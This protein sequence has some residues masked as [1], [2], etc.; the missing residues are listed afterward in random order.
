[1]ALLHALVQ[2]HL[3]GM[4]Q[5]NC[6]KE[7]SALPDAEAGLGLFHA[8]HTAL[9]RQATDYCTSGNTALARGD[10][11]ALAKR[12][13]T[14]L[15]GLFPFG[16]ASNPDA[17]LAVTKRFFLDY[18]AQRGELR[19]KI[20][21]AGKRWQRV[22]AFLDRLDTAADFFQTS[23]A[24]GSQSRPLGLDVTFRYLPQAFDRAL[25]GSSQLIGWRFETGGAEASYP[26]G[27]TSLNWRFGDPV[28]MHLNWAG[29][30]SYRP[31]ADDAQTHLDVNEREASFSAS[32]PWSLLRL[33]EARRDTE[34]GMADPLNHDRVITAISIPL[35]FT[36][37]PG[38]TKTRNAKLRLAL[39]LVASDASGKPG[40][41]LSLP[42]EFPSK[43][44][45]LW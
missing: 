23:L 18:A 28:A 33:I 25:G 34:P 12:F 30:S 9:T 42:T 7:L 40:A 43:A 27:N 45:Y 3:R 22:N 4:S 1:V 35:K 10:Y 32:G 11:R 5:A 24:A 31:E 29:L 44:P 36:Q 15:A 26:N 19:R 38:T 37:P 41:Q 39:D 2:K 20:N 17:P 13:N 6:T 8:R 21:G 14:E 16:P